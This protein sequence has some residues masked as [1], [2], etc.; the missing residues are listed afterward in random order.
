MT[1]ITAA[2]RA[3]T[4]KPFISAASGVDRSMRNGSEAVREFAQQG[5]AYSQDFFE[6]TK[7]A[8][9][10]TNKVLEQ[11]FATATRGAA[12]FNQEWLEMARHNINAAFDLAARLAVVK[13]PTEFVELS[14]D[15]ARKQVETFGKQ[16]QHLAALAQ[17]LTTDTVRPLQAGVT[18]AVNKVA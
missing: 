10:Q 7:A 3:R 4:A 9:E 2:A 8:A 6:Q 12:E 5:A 16:A 13:S 1:E 14:A 17:K 15:H 11:T 18:G